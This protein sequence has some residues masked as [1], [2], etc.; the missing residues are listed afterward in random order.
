MYYTLDRIEENS[1][2]VFTDENGKVYNKKISDL[3]ENS[4]PGD[5]FSLENNIFIFNAAE[6]SL[7][8]QRMAEKKDKFFGRLRKNKEE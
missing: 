6:T 3:P 2:A 7:R 8:K 4:K 5:V 1:V